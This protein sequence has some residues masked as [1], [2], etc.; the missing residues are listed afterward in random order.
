VSSLPT[1]SSTTPLT[2]PRLIQHAAAMVM[3]T[4]TVGAEAGATIIGGGMAGIADGTTNR[5][6]A[7]YDGA[8]VQVT[9]VL[10]R[11]T[12]DSLGE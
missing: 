6:S 4:I 7:A 3:V 1:A 8:T 9:C 2:E 10:I 12:M 11:L 5:Q